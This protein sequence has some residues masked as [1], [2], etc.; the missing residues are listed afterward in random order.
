M[1]A[2]TAALVSLPL[3]ATG[4]HPSEPVDEVA[5][6]PVSLWAADRLTAYVADDRRG[7]AEIYGLYL[8][9]HGEPFELWSSR[10]SY[11]DPI[12]TEW[13][14]SRATVVLPRAMKSF[15]GL[16]RFLRVRII[17]RSGR[18]VD[19]LNPTIC[20]SGPA[21]RTRPEAPSASPYPIGCPYHP[22]TLGSVQGIQAGWATQLLGLKVHLDPGRYRVEVAIAPRYVRRLGLDPGSTSRTV[23]LS[24]VSIPSPG[25][26]QGIDPT[27]E[28]V[29]SPHRTAPTEA[30]AGAPGTSMVDLRSLPAFGMEVN[31]KGTQL[32]FGATS[33]NAG[34]SPLVIDGFRGEGED[35]MEAYQYF[36]DAAGNQVGHQRV[37]HLH[38]HRENHDHWHFEDF[39]RYRLL[40]PDGSV[41]MRSF[42][43]SWCL[44]N[45]DA[46]DYTR[47]GAAWQPEATDLATAC[48]G[49]SALSI[50][51]VLAPGSGDTYYQFRAG[52]AFKIAD[53]P[54]G[55]Y[56]VEVEANPLGNLVESDLT[57]NVAHRTIWLRGQG[58]HRRVVVAK[59]GRIEESPSS[60]S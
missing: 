23:D 52:Q 47:P 56:V 18:T 15:R 51:E 48:G 45:T 53:L 46:V 59:V 32:R 26:A 8:R 11:A 9:A 14:S 16:K 49:E 20:L 24:V 19:R 40:R 10:S 4:A 17:D 7:G 34:D 44:A 41:A 35:E 60:R 21:E 6:G 39:A 42:K 30:A 36:Y 43:Q 5:T 27:D 3:A 12:R 37:G 25:G 33:W 29:T 31:P 38:Y 2:L 54:N 13:R 58:E 28:G 50:R 1:G 22:Y 57:N 55:K